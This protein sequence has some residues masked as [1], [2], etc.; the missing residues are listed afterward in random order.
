MHTNKD[1]PHRLERSVVIAAQPETVFRFFTD[2]A[3]WASWWGAGST[4]DARPGGRV[5]V[6][7]PNGI[8]TLGE[9]REIDNPERIVFTFGYP[10][11]KPMPPEGSLVT[12]WLEPHESGTLL[13]LTHDFAEPG[14]RDEFIQGWR[15]QLALFA[16]AVADEAHAN[17]AAVVDGW[18]A[19]WMITEEQ[20]RAEA[21]AKV[22]SPGVIFRDRFALIEGS[23]ELG[24]HIAA[25]HRFMP[26]MSLK[27]KGDV[28]HCQGTVLSDWVASAADGTPRMSGTSVFVFGPDGKISSATGVRNA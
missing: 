27:R 5:Y 25:S 6:R 19:A 18:Y 1:L 13:R 11:G 23:D 10:S 3:R 24:K 26:G 8:E 12:I 16:N 15:F 4:I 22:A 21:I 28:R 17:A 2:S 20:A 7:H 9:I 14:P